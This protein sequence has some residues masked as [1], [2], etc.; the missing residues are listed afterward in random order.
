MALEEGLIRK[1]SSLKLEGNS[2]FQKEKPDHPAAIEKYIEALKVQLPDSEETRELRAQLHN[3][4]AKCFYKLFAFTLA[5]Q[6]A[7][8]ARKL[9][10][11]WFKTYLCCG[12]I[13]HEQYKFAGAVVQFTKALEFASSD[14]EK[15][16][17]LPKLEK[18]EKAKGSDDNLVPTQEKGFR[19]LPV[20]EVLTDFKCLF[21]Q[22][23]G[24]E[25]KGNMYDQRLQPITDEQPVLHRILSYLS[26][27][28]KVPDSFVKFTMN[29]KDFGFSTDETR[30][31]FLKKRLKSLFR[32]RCRVLTGLGADMT[33][34]WISWQVQTFTADSKICGYRSDDN[35]LLIALFSEDEIENFHVCRT[36]QF[37]EELNVLLR[38]TMI[39]GLHKD[40]EERVVPQSVRIET[41]EKVD[42]KLVEKGLEDFHINFEC[43]LP[44]IT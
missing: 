38:M 30:L 5:L 32:T 21:G 19:Q 10:P 7:K 13:L 25:L 20:R 40:A 39:K 28:Y 44:E 3:N 9:A 43:K 1:V 15:K 2:L 17:V 34:M 14:E 6:H 8:Q 26:P 23:P 36:K 33:S 18:S 16:L 24:Y 11:K 22:H 41:I 35:V 27:Q 42:M 29:P 4:L 12:E 31:E 37:S